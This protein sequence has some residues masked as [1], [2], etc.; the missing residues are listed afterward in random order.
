MTIDNLIKTLINSNIEEYKE[1][2]LY[3]IINDATV[4][5]IEEMLPSDYS[6][7]EEKEKQ[8]QEFK[9]NIEKYE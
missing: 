2:R 6:Y 1:L 5:F 4:Q 7:F 8:Y 9:K 3:G